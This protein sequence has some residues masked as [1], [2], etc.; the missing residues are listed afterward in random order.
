MQIVLK[1]RIL[2][3]FN[4]IEKYLVGRKVRYKSGNEI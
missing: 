1:I 4:K 3:K 2:S